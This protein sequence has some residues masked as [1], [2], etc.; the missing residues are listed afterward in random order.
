MA[1]GRINITKIRAQV[2]QNQ[3]IDQFALSLV[4]D[5]F[6][7]AKNVM[8]EEFENHPVTQEILS[9][10]LGANI[11][12]TLSNATVPGNLYA[13]LGFDSDGG[14]EEIHKLKL[15]IQNQTY[16]NTVPVRSSNSNIIRYRF[17][18]RVPTEEEIKA[19]TPVQW[20]DTARGRSWVAIIENGTNS[21]SY[22]L[23][24]K[25]A[26]GRSKEALQAKTKEGKLIV[27]NYGQFQKTP[28]TTEIIEKFV[29]S[30]G[31]TVI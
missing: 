1:F 23:Y 28:Y 2:A 12:D 5:K 7:E 9:G 29:R 15:L 16:L 31:S 4:Q 8:L 24:K 11:S 18:G 14:D 21:F 19:A 17:T 3:A 30:V 6:D 22:Y 20:G 27:V 13:F 26:D 25:F 10:P